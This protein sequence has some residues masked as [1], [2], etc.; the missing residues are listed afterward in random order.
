MYVVLKWLIIFSILFADSD[1]SFYLRTLSSSGVSSGYHPQ[2]QFVSRAVSSGV[3]GSSAAGAGT[4]R[5][6]KVRRR[7]AYYSRDRRDIT[8]STKLNI[9]AEIFSERH[10]WALTQAYFF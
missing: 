5:R 2:P 7:K 8:V 3:V 9:F 10:T 1:A 4:R 6:N